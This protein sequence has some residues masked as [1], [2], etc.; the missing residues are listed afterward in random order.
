MVKSYQ[1][2][3]W[4]TEKT[5]ATLY[6]YDSFGN[7]VK[8]TLALNATPTKDNSPVVEL[9]HS[10]ESAADGVY[11]VTT[12]THYN[13]EGAALNTTK[14]Q[15]ISQ[16]SSTIENKSISISERG[17]TSTLWAAYNT[18]TNRTTYSNIPASTITTETVTVDGFVVSRKDNIGITSTEVRAYMQ[19]AA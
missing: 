13:S 1:D 12:Q 17:L 5:A 7:Q 10:V 18:G 11:R 2:T 6:E 4:N 16:L 3:G 19:Q 14:K 9:V 8:Q 15:L